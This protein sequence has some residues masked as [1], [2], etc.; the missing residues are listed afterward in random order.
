MVVVVV[1]LWSLLQLGLFWALVYCCIRKLGF[2]P[3]VSLFEA[4]H[5]MVLPSLG[6]A[7]ITLGTVLLLQ[8]VLGVRYFVRPIWFSSS[9]VSIVLAYMALA[10]VPNQA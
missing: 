6:H 9:N 4:P 7:A 1:V 10:L 5:R 8:L 3:S 2:L